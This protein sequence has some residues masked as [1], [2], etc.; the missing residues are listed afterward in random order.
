M[1]H[2]PVSIL[3]I[4]RL[5]VNCAGRRNVDIHHDVCGGHMHTYV[6]MCMCMQV[7][8]THMHASHQIRHPMAIWASHV[9]RNLFSGGLSHLQSWPR[10]CYGLVWPSVVQCVPI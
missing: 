8:F 7:T 6:I 5:H 9:R 10:T 3:V 4:H 2:N 1:Y